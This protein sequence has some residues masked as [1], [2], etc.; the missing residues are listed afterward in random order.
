MRPKSI[1]GGGASELRSSSREGRRRERGGRRREAIGD[2]NNPEDVPGGRLLFRHFVE[3]AGEVLDVVIGDARDGDAS[4][5]GAVDVVLLPEA[6]H[7]S[8]V[9]S[10]SGREEGQSTCSLLR[11][12]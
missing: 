8:L 5:R 9:R 12:V 1:G 10:V 6:V 7:L 3:G 11:P 2:S 4:V